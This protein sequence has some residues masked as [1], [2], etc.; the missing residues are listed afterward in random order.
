MSGKYFFGFHS[1]FS[2]LRID[3][4]PDNAAAIDD[5]PDFSADNFAFAPADSFFV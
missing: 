4:G 5:L 2:D 1:L 3:G